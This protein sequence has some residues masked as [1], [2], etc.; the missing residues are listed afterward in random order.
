MIDN[1]WYPPENLVKNANVTKVMDNLNIKSYKELVNKSIEDI[2][3]F[4]DIL[5]KIIDVVWFKRYTKVLDISNG[6]M[7]AKWYRGGRINLVYN[8]LDRHIATREDKTAF[9]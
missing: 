4:W 8:S 3:W 9:I 1:I 2:E 5:N 7:W 6:I